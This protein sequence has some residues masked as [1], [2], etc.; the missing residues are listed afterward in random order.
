MRL[1]GILASFFLGCVM[2][3]ACGEGGKK[4]QSC[5]TDQQC[6]DGVCYE[7]ECYTVCETWRDCAQD[8]LCETKARD[9][10]SRVDVCVASE[11]SPESTAEVREESSDLPPWQATSTL[12]VARLH[13]VAAAPGNGYLY[14]S[15]GYVDSSACAVGTADGRTFFA[16]QNADGSL[17]AWTE[18]A[19]GPA[20]FW[21][22]IA[23]HAEANGFIYVAGGANNGPAWDGSVWFT[24]PNADGTISSWTLASNPIG[25]WIGSAP[26]MAASDGVLYVGAGFNAFATPQNSTLLVS[27][28]LDASTGQPGAWTQL[29]ALPAGASNGQLV[30]AGDHAYL[31]L[32]ASDEVYLAKRDALADPSPWQLS[33]TALPATPAY[34]NVHVVGGDL[35]LALGG[36]T[37]IFVSTLQSD[38]ALGPWSVSSRAP[39]PVIVGYQGIVANGFYYIIGNDDCEATEAQATATYFLPLP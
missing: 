9:D 4:T 34:P 6:S 32:G 36:T 30:F 13:A 16:K 15:N 29:G 7:N 37:D 28:T 25:A 38:G 22:S 2:T 39:V 11:L 27:A 3:I 23:G 8:Q 26:I 12:P 1:D 19:V 5:D 14:V 18:T 17:G 10:G 20:G 31:L 24:K 21:R 35:M 33:A